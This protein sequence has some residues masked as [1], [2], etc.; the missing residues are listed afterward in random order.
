MY[1][2]VYVHG[3]VY[4][5]ICVFMYTVYANTYA[6][7]HAYDVRLHTKRASADWQLKLSGKHV[8]I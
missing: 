2:C 1:V 3:F 5:Y 7:P 4:V 6:H 8:Y